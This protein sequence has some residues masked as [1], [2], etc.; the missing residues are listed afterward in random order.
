M[1]AVEELGWTQLEPNRAV[2]EPGG[3]ML[4]LLGVP[5]LL[6]AE[7]GLALEYD[8]VR[9]RGQDTG[10]R[11]RAQHRNDNEREERLE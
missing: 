10:H 7:A 9:W 6:D 3:G 5:D 4:S 8:G 2:F 11:D 1:F